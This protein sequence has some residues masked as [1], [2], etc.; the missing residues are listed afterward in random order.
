MG[1]PRQVGH[2][3]MAMGELAVH[4]RS[5]RSMLSIPIR[6]F[7]ALSLSLGLAARVGPGF[8]PDRPLAKDTVLKSATVI[9]TDFRNRQSH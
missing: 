1:L 3:P 9:S 6:L 4:S 8:A 5:P 7:G 2:G